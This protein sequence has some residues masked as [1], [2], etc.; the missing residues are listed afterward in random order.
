MR[1]VWPGSSY[2]LLL[3][4]YTASLSSL[5]FRTPLSPGVT[6]LLTFLLCFLYGL[7]FFY[8]LMP[9]GPMVLPSMLFSHTHSIWRTSLMS[10]ASVV[11]YMPMTSNLWFRLVPLA[12]FSVSTF[13]LPH[14]LSSPLEHPRGA[15]TSVCPFTI[16]PL[17]PTSPLIVAGIQL[18][19]KSY[20]FCLQN[21]LWICPLL[22][23]H[24]SSGP[25]HLFP[26]I[27]ANAWLLPTLYLPYSKNFSDWFF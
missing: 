22:F 27:M 14:L 20:L 11:T 10:N 8:L 25:H 6:Y 9:V 16:L 23:V 3:P 1:S 12:E 18:P 2:Y 13:S 4:A 24:V 5:A 7:L 15:P 26:W 19:S 21:V 17:K